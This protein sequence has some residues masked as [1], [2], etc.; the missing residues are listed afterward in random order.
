MNNFNFM[1]AEAQWLEDSREEP[2][3][4]YECEC[5]EEIVE[6]DDYFEYE[7]QNYC[8]KK[9]LMD[10]IRADIKEND[11]GTYEYACEKFDDYEEL[12]DFIDDGICKYTA[13]KED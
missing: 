4:V 11:D 8:C 10:D 9:C 1:R 13:E 5:G 2:Q 3:V 7:G 12:L 6:G